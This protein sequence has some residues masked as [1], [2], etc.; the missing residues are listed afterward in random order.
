M[1]KLAAFVL[2]L[3]VFAAM[4]APLSAAA[5]SGSS[6]EKLIALTFDDGPS[7]QT[8]R[9]L[10]ALAEYGAKATFFVSGYR[11]DEYADEL[12]RIAAEGHQLGNHTEN[13]KT[14]TKLSASQ[15]ALEVETTLARIKKTAGDTTYVLRPVGGAYNKAVCAAAKGPVI[16][17]SVD[18]LDWKNR[19][20]DS[21]YNKIMSASDGDIV[22]MHDLY[23]TTVDAVCR[24]LPELERRG[25]TLV[26][27]SELFRR[28][29]VTLE[30]GE[31]YSSARAYPVLEETAESAYAGGRLPGA[32]LGA[33]DCGE[34][35]Y[36]ADVRAQDFAG[37]ETLTVSTPYA[38]VT[39][40]REAVEDGAL[41]VRVTRAGADVDIAV[42]RD[43][44]RLESIPGGVTVGLAGKG[45]S[46]ASTVVTV[47]DGVRTPVARSAAV[48]ES[49]MRA[50][51]PGS[52]AVGVE[53]AA[54]GTFR[55][56]GEPWAKNA[57]DFVSARG[58]LSGVSQDMFGVYTGMTRGML[59][60]V[61]WRMEGKPAASGK[62]GFSDVK[63]GQYYAEAIAWAAE[64]GIVSGVGNGKFAPE[65][66]LTREQAV[67]ILA[68][69]FGLTA[70]AE[71]LSVDG[72]SGNGQKLPCADWAA[73]AYAGALGAG[74]LR[75]T[76]AAW[77]RPAGAI[78]RTEAA[79][80]LKRC[81]EAS[82]RDF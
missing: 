49:A 50:W 25:Y 62:A 73:D 19:N 39:L 23:R 15:L 57:V 36:A 41:T 55:D 54:A 20:A 47:Q 76:D 75:E 1:K 2:I 80:L 4:L 67:T 32:M 5:G 60:A 27:V 79:V 6:G 40:R 14:L 66:A 24:A 78:S 58:L 77:A 30:N 52:A 13:H 70:D 26:T 45:F 3:T 12:E 37:E 53:T 56:A 72:L 7:V 65:S 17:W 8:D 61:L 44:E 64:N 71:G 38:G 51:L 68:R 43:G 33:E 59:A 16:L 35:G 46:A 63:A 74:V 11:L 28:R 31:V 18:T 9:L 10:D 21:V 81:I 69:V 48:S 82:L 42:M 29:G 34:D 22:L